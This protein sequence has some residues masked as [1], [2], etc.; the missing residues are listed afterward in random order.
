MN[1]PRHLKEIVENNTV[2]LSKHE[3]D[4][5]VSWSS[6]PTREQLIYYVFFDIPIPILY[7]TLK[8]NI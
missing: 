3:S 1:L 7:I 4:G 5:K 8:K 6:V 2:F